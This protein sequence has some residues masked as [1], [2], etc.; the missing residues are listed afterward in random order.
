MAASTSRL[1]RRISRRLVACVGSRSARTGQ[2][3][4]QQRDLNRKGAH[5]IIGV[6]AERVGAAKRL[7]LGKL[8][9]EEKEDARHADERCGAMDTPGRPVAHGCGPAQ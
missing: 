1:P 5:Q 9:E 2:H 6:L 8:K 7:A 4:D 3:A